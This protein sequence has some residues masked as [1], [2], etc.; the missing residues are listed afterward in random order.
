MTPEGTT[1]T[2]SLINNLSMRISNLDTKVRINEQNILNEGRRIQLVNK[3]VLDFKKEIRE[4]VERLMEASHDLQK[5]LEKLGQKI[6]I[7]EE[8]QKRKP[9]VNVQTLPLTPEP[10]SPDDAL[11]NVLNMLKTKS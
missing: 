10:Q 4:K 9:L 6:E 7:I 11:Q 8:L 3:N 1:D 5:A 2:R